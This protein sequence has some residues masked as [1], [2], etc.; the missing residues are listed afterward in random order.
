MGRGKSNGGAKRGP[1]PKATKADLEAAVKLLST[2]YKSVKKLVR[3]IH[4][5]VVPDSTEGTPEPETAEPTLE[6][7]TAETPASDLQ[8]PAAATVVVPAQAEV[9]VGDVLPVVA[10][11]Q[12]VQ[13]S[14][15]LKPANG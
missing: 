15:N 8:E 14:L 10:Q 4:A 3:Q 12:P 2:Q 5:A 6:A 11:T 13:S 7:I 9:K 1:K